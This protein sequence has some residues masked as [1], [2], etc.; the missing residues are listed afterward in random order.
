ME[1]ER[2]ELSEAGNSRLYQRTEPSDAGNCRLDQERTAVD[3]W[4]S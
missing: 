3:I 1:E 4:I 2:T